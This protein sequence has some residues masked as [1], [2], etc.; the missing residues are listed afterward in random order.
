[1]HLFLSVLLTALIVPLAAHAQA[2]PKQV[3]VVNDPLV[4]E[5][6]N[7]APPA[8][9][10]RFQLVGF[11]SATML[12]NA[13]VL[14]LT[15]ACQQEFNGSRMCNSVEV[16][17]TVMVPSGLTGNAWVRPFFVPF[18]Q[19]STSS[20]PGTGLDASGIVGQA[21]EFSCVGSRGFAVTA[22]G[23]FIS[24]QFC[25]DPRPVACCALMP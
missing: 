9:P 22:T 13:G 7:P 17:E 23:I 21:I 5:V 3:E 1:M 11:T 24:S 16:I 2:A 8:P 12:G 25:S 4:V 20:S 10:A 19:V 15:L 6:V 14:S 18:Q